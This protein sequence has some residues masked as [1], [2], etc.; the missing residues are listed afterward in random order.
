[1]NIYHKDQTEKTLKAYAIL[2]DQSNRSLA[3][4]ELF[5]LFEIKGEAHPYTLGTCS[6]T[7]EVSGRRAHGLMVSS[8][9]VNLQLPLPTLVEC[10]QIP[11]NREEIPTPAAAF[12]H[13]HLKVI[14][15]EIP[16][17]DK[18]AQILLLL[19]RDILRVHKVHRQVSG[20]PDAPFAQRMDLGW[21]IIGNV[22]IGKMKRPT[23]ISSF[24][25]NVLPNGRNT[26]FEPCPHHYWVKEKIASHG[27][28]HGIS[29]NTS[30]FSCHDDDF[31][32]TVFNTTSEDD[33]LAPST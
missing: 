29:G 11:A 3:K 15:N 6:G 13:P 1:M 19:G 9:K 8:L 12:H 32:S 16:P 31:G 21:V 18:D 24:K 20:P 30:P 26:Y 33:I 14:A 2:D 28:Q 27:W 22:C 17:L 25:T 7:T 23:N 5:N 4:S 10:N